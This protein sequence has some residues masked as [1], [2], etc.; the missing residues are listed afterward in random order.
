MERKCG[1]SINLVFAGLILGA[2]LI[3]F[4]SSCVSGWLFAAE[5]TDG[6][7][8]GEIR[9]DWADAHSIFSFYLEHE[10]NVPPLFWEEKEIRRLEDDIK[11]L[12]QYYTRTGKAGRAV[13][14]YV[15][16]NGERATACVPIFSAVPVDVIGPVLCGSELKNLE[17]IR[18]EGTIIVCRDVS[19]E[20]V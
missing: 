19:G 7:G 9:V 5:I 18:T 4:L 15:G 2:L 1:N 16:P 6:S 3:G 20:A 17:F 12:Q 13:G 14:F 11:C 8:A 10:K